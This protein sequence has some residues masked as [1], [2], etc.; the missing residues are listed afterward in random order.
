[1]DFYSNGT[2]PIVSHNM[3]RHKHYNDFLIRNYNNPSMV[4]E[5]EYIHKLSTNNNMAMNLLSL[6]K[7]CIYNLE[8]KYY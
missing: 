6:N 2:V 8:R 5:E 4:Q 1:M 3:V 7:T